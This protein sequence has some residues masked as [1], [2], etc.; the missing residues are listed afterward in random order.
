MEILILIT[1]AMT[2]A[3]CGFNLFM[4]NMLERDINHLIDLIECM[5][6]LENDQA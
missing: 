6:T 4:I 2:L 5:E 1:L 3:V